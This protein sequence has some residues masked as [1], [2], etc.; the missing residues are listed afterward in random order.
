MNNLNGVISQEKEGFLFERTAPAK[1]G[2]PLYLRGSSDQTYSKHIP[3][4]HTTRPIRRVQ[5]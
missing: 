5:F 4:T 2:S 1:E 3:T